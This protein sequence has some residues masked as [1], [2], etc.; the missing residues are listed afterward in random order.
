MEKDPKDRIG[1]RTFLTLGGALG[2]TLALSACTKSAAR[3]S[4]AAVGGGPSSML[5]SALSAFYVNVQGFGAAGD[6]VK[7][8]TA[9]LQSA[10][11]AAQ[12]IGGA[13]FLPP[14]TFRISAPLHTSNRLT[15]IGCGYEGDRG[16]GYAGKTMSQAT[17]F[18]AS[19]IVCGDH[20]GIV[21]TTDAAVTLQGFQITYPARPSPTTAAITL[22]SSKSTTSSNNGSLIRDVLVYGH[23]VGIRLN[24]CLDFVVDNA[25]LILGYLAGIQI[26]SPNY[27]NFGDSTITNST[28]WGN[29]IPDYACHVQVTSGGGLRFINNKLNFGGINTTGVLIQP[30]LTVQ[31]NV[32]PLIIANNSIEGCAVGVGFNNGN[33]LASATMVSITGN[34]IWAGTCTIYAYPYAKPWIAGISIVG[35]NLQVN[36]GAA[37]SVVGL[38][39]V[40]FGVITGNTL[41]LTGGAG[42]GSGISLGPKTSLINVIGNAYAGGIGVSNNGT[43]NSIGVATP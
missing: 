16:L 39:G 3:T 19:V 11:D 1:R 40:Q 15:I 25:N 43:G 21:A 5:A 2:G 8:D 35:N 33:P 42:T 4:L 31:Q 27:P 18:H 29:S 10:I 22:Q 7:D 28:I 36:S 6:G 23:S 24:N 26:S 34:E 12:A 13:V 32:E 41:S 17:G 37:R 9:A 20:D 30:N 38:D 14:G